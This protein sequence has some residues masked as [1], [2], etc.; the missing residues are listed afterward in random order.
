MEV[1][2]KQCEEWTDNTSET[3]NSLIGERKPYSISSNSD[4][5]QQVAEPATKY[6]RD[7]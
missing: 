7:K 6:E 5:L 4:F 3:S 1:V 2:L